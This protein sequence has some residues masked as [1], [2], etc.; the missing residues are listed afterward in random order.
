MSINSIM[1]IHYNKTKLIKEII[2]ELPIYYGPPGHQGVKGEKGNNGSQIFT[3]NGAPSNQFGT[4]GDFYINKTNGDNYLKINGF[5]IF[6][7]NFQGG[8]LC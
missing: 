7:G 5:W 3:G 6:Q 2:S 8:V 4:N 1:S